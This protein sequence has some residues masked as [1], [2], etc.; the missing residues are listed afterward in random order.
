MAS[1]LFQG[2][3]ATPGLVD[4]AVR[5]YATLEEPTRVTHGLVAAAV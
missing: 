1:D 3:G 2:M 5:D 4:I